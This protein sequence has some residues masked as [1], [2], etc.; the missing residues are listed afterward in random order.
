MLRRACLKIKYWE[1][2][3]FTIF[4]LFIFN[5]LEITLTAT[6]H[7][8]NLYITVHNSP[9]MASTYIEKYSYFLQ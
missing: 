3:F 7:I 2:V 1:P 9:T 8:I 6:L 5:I 4:I